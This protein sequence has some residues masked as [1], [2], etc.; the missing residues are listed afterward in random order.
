MRPTC[1]TTLV[2][3]LAC[4]VAAG[5]AGAASD[6]RIAALQS[7]LRVQGH[8]AGIVDGVAGPE[9]DVALR[10]F[11][12]KAGLA[13]DGVAGAQTRAALGPLGRPAFGTRDLRRGLVGWDVSALQFLLH[14]HG[15]LNGRVDGEFGASTDTA[16]RRFQGRAGLRADGIVGAATRTA[17]AREVG[18]RASAPARP[19]TA[20]PRAA[21]GDRR[22]TH[23]VRPGETLTSIA[24]RYS[25]S[26]PALARANG[27]DPA[28]VL[29][30]A[31]RLRVPAPTAG[32]PAGQ[33][34]S[35]R[36]LLDR[37]AA[38][39]GIDPRLLRALAWQESGFQNHV[40]SS[41]GAF[42]VMQVTPATWEFVE[43]VLLRRKVERTVEG[44][45]RV[46]AAFLAHLL[47]RFGGNE[48]LALAAYY[49]GPEAVIRYGLGPETTRYVENVL[50]LRQRM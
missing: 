50:A 14:R 17:L 18:A 36:L 21:P 30:V 39:Y 4:L 15:V 20:S 10:A 32:P 42:G 33:S 16:V 5:P 1:V 8:Y 7:A 2:A 44:N 38:H 40:V 28:R 27:L 24:G 46:G 12:R 37:W 11:Q 35:V 25:T 31:S 3:A 41:A 23:V 47:R 6:P 48:R 34:L 13:A 45:V 29:P 43:L 9:T 22:L 19:A 26:V 49:R